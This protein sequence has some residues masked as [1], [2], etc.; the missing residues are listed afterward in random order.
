MLT[1]LQTPVLAHGAV[2]PL[3]EILLVLAIPI[4]G[5]LLVLFVRLLFFNRRKDASED[6][7]HAGTDGP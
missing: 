2:G 3:D 5:L 6:G 7:D 4:F 1:M